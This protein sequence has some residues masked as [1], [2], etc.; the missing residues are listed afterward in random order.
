[1][2]KYNS[3]IIRQ[4]E[5][6]KI[7][8][9]V[10]VY[11]N[12]KK[13]AEKVRQDQLKDI[14]KDYSILW[15]FQT[16]YK[17][18]KQYDE[19]YA[20][21]P[22]NIRD[23]R[24][25]K[26]LNDTKS[27]LKTDEAKKALEAAA[28]HEDLAGAMANGT[29]AATKYKESATQQANATTSLISSSVASTAKMVALNAGIAIAFELLIAGIAYVYDQIANANKRTIEEGTKVEEKYQKKIDTGTS[30]LSTLKSIKPEYTQLSAGVDDQGNNVSLSTSE[31]AKFVELRSQ[32]LD[33]NPSLISGYDAEGNAIANNNNLLEQA[34]EL[35]QKKVQN[36][37]EDRASDENFSKIADK[38]ATQVEEARGS[39]KDKL[40][41]KD[42]E[43]QKNDLLTPFYMDE[44]K[45]ADLIK[46]S[47][48]VLNLQD[49]DLSN[50]SDV[51]KIAKHF[52]T[53][54]DKLNETTKTGL[55]KDILSGYAETVADHAETIKKAVDDVHTSLNYIPQS[56]DGFAGLSANQQGFVNNIVSNWEIDEK[57][58]DSKGKDYIEILANKVEDFASA[59]AS[60]PALQTDINDLI[61][62]TNKT[63]SKTAS[64]WQDN[65]KNR[66]KDLADTTGLDEETIAV[67][68]G[69]ELQDGNIIKDGKNIQTMID[70]INHRFENTDAAKAFTESLSMDELSNAFEI[71]NSK[72]EI[73]TGTLDQLKE[74]MKILKQSNNVSSWDD[75]TAAT[76]STNSGAKYLAI[77]EGFEARKK[78]YDNG[79]TGTDEFK[80][81]TSLAS[82]SGKDTEAAFR[83]VSP[84][85]ERY[86][87]EDGDGLSNFLEDM[88]SKTQKLG[89]D[90][91]DVS[92]KNGKWNINIKDMAKA[93]KE[94]GIGLE[95]FEAILN[96]LK[97]YNFNVKFDSSEEKFN[98]ANSLLDQ[99]A[100]NYSN[101]DDSNPF[102]KEYGEEIEGWRQKILKLKQANE[103]IP[104]EWIKELKLKITVDDYEEKI[105]NAVRQGESYE[106][107]GN[108]SKAEKHYSTA[109]SYQDF[110][111]Q[112]LEK[113]LKES[114]IEIPVELKEDKKE[115]D[116]LFEK[117]S[118]TTDEKA[119]VK[120]EKDIQDQY[121]DYLTAL[122]DLESGK[123]YT[124][125][126]NTKD[127]KSTDNHQKLD[128]SSQTG[129]K[130]ETVSFEADTSDVEEKE[131]E[132]SEKE[133][134]KTVKVKGD[135]TEAQQSVLEWAGIEVTKE[136]KLKG[137]ITDAQQKVLEWLGIKV[138]KEGKLTGNTTSATQAVQA[139]LA[140]K[141]IKT[142]KLKADTSNATTTVQNWASNPITRTVNLA[143]GS[144]TGI[145]GAISAAISALGGG[146][147]QG[148]AHSQGTA[149]TKNSAYAFGS[150]RKHKSS[151]IP[152]LSRRAL[153]MGTLSEDFDEEEIEPVEMTAIDMASAAYARG[154]WG[155]KQNETALTGELGQELVVNCATMH[156]NVY[157]KIYLI[158]GKS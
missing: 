106:K 61:K 53:I 21:E 99:M 78:D 18:K 102:K 103:E 127:Q 25:Q 84:K 11:R 51:G 86:F 45:K 8:S 55:N 67:G 94:A 32:I 34:I 69:L 89:T 52:D 118:K 7:Q 101:L 5:D 66:L 41:G 117:L 147:A 132:I 49:I 28:A 119:R 104:D 140:S 122:G 126:Q 135:I 137:D 91:F 114:K 56:I 116:G 92:E 1:M 43:S 3:S 133:T 156:S 105:D 144:L 77:K 23:K 146:K 150:P 19:E 81:F 26:H 17:S 155:L 79:L 65:I 97:D 83:Q 44:K 121:D 158:A 157:V 82:K 109:I 115:I 14:N 139:W 120:I 60:D 42:Y 70:D 153:A 46:A 76:E 10:G 85:M 39:W 22:S 37:K 30:N 100:E 98:T 107:Q 151:S 136:G 9:V 124:K 31:Y 112:D 24:Y 108:F 40:F 38:Y 141:A 20:H 90:I 125:K 63:D 74:R 143:V 59:V 4:A 73:F 111:A 54:Y 72:A 149:T 88:Q 128:S 2:S 145:G 12:R 16:G 148:T 87:T 62:V 131:K 47:K 64:E 29:D 110:E 6:G 130:T 33:M 80:T 152:K 138:S 68:I 50:D 95:P 57:E 129:G 154:D 96:R 123:T 13:D 15:E 27:Q 93:A 48:E 71:V 113:N 75:Y 142:G 36:A 134:E 35:Q 58:L